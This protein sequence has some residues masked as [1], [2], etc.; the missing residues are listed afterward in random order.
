MPRGRPGLRGLYGSAVNALVARHRKWRVL[1]G[2]TVRGAL[3]QPWRQRARRRQF[4]TREG[5]QGLFRLQLGSLCADAPRLGCRDPPPALLMGVQQRWRL[6][7]APG[8]ART[9]HGH[10]PRARAP[11]ALS[12]VRP[13]RAR[14]RDPDER[15]R[16]RARCPLS[17]HSVPDRLFLRQRSRLVGGGAVHLLFVETCECC[18]QAALDRAVATPLRRRLGALYPPISSRRK[19]SIHGIGSSPPRNGRE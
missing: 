1:A 14:D 13:V 15:A 4:R 17:Q 7:I 10:Q 3:L 2:D 8:S 5:R 6:G 18:D 12:L 19:Q 11:R 9:S 16:P